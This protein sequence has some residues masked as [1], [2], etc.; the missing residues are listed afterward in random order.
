MPL[1]NFNAGPCHL[2]QEVVEQASAAVLNFENTGLSILEIPHRGDRFKAVMEEARSLAHELMELEDDFEVLFLHGGGRTQFLEVAMNLLDT[3]KKAAYINTGSWSEKAIAEARL[4]GEVDEIASSGDKNYSYIPKKYS[5][6]EDAGY[7]HI[8]SNNTI[9]G[10]EF[11]EIPDSPIPL[12]ADMSSNI[13]SRAIDFNKFSLIYAGAQKNIGAAGVT[14]VA[15]RKSILGKIKRAIPV[16]M[17]YQVHIDK[18]SM[19]NTPPVFAVYVCLLNL[20]WLK[21]Q[22]GVKEI[23]KINIQKATL[24]YDEIDKNPL[25]RGT[26]AKEDRSRMNACFVMENKELEQP[27]LDFC[28]QKGLLNIKG[29]RSV[30]GFRVS[31]YNAITLDEVQILVSAM[32]EFSSKNP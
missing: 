16:I 15:V 19:Y 21:A 24:L 4:Y 32:Q 18:A 1:H 25:F 17:D 31:M 11:Q 29:H 9:A 8:T 20:R 26:V 5:I 22:G 23:E 14:M 30:G 7:L 13:L 10:T 2:P 6:P 12:V 28:T 3:G 27:F